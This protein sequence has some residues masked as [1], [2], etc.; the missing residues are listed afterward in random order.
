MAQEDVSSATERS[1]GQ[2]GR[3]KLRMLDSPPASPSTNLIAASKGERDV[4]AHA[5]GG[6]RNIRS[7][8]SLSQLRLEQRPLR[9]L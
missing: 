9:A 6:D 1:P 4:T 2:E 8:Q 5:E 7:R 3:R